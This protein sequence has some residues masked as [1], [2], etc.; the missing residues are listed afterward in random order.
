MENNIPTINLEV[1]H[2]GIL[3]PA[4]VTAQYEQPGSEDPTFDLKGVDANGTFA[5]IEAHQSTAIL[6]VI[7][8]TVNFE[9]GIV[10]G[11][12]WF[13]GI[14]PEGNIIEIPVERSRS[15][16]VDYGA[17]W[18]FCWIAGSDGLVVQNSTEPKFHPDMEVAIERG[19]DKD[20][21]PPEYWD[22]IDELKN[23]V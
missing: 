8:P 9:D 17:G 12:G 23:P 22:R 16:L 3:C 20:T 2:Q 21:L 7:H 1:S 5:A 15:Q 10:G 11:F 4:H 19:S 13:L 18:T 6:Q 14:N